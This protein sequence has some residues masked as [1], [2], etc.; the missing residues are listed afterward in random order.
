LLVLASAGAAIALFELTYPHPGQGGRSAAPPKG[1]GDLLAWTLASGP[2]GVQL[3]GQE[4][5]DGIRPCVLPT[6]GMITPILDPA[7]GLPA[8]I[9]HWQ[10]G[11]PRLW[12]MSLIPDA[13]NAPQGRPAAHEGAAPCPPGRVLVPADTIM[14]YLY[15][16]SLQ[17]AAAR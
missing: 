13:T 9:A 14:N 8:R 12:L 2:P 16:R 5:I 17:A 10:A 1:A 7:S 11:G 6:T 4:E 15:E 3:L